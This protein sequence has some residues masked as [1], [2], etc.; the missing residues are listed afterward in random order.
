MPAQARPTSPRVVAVVLNWNGEA[1]TRRCVEALQ[2][3]DYPNLGVLVVDNGSAD[4]SGERLRAVAEVLALGE[5]LGFGGGMNRGATLAISRGAAYVLVV[6]NDAVLAP[7]CVSRLAAA[8]FPIAA[9]TIVQ[10]LPPGEAPPIVQ[11]LPPAEAPLIV[12]GRPP[13]EALPIASGRPPAE[14]PLWYAGGGVSPWTGEPHHDTE[15]PGPGAPPRAVSFASGCCLLVDAAAW[16]LLGGFDEAFFL[17][18][19]DV[20]FCLRARRA[21]L[22][23]G[24]V[25]AARAW[26]EGGASTA[27]QATKAPA[28][29][30]YDARN[31]L[32]VARTR[33]GLLQRPIA[34]YW[35]LNVRLPRKLARI[36]LTAPNR[37]ASLHA[38]LRGAW[39]GLLGRSGPA[40]L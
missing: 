11:G 31:G 19:E 22:P 15:P 34:L 35:W 33:L 32:R 39:D 21:H 28:L 29:D 24:W 20:D 36:V 7:D 9:P 37:G 4:G 25:P 40:P 8:A 6:N 23:I 13:A 12:S 5:N 1:A 27:S 10:G 30:Y 14:A 2:A 16:R 17:Y 3:Q 26:H 38:A 18:H